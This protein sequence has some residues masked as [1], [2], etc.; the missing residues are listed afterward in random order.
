MW[1]TCHDKSLHCE[2]AFR[3]LCTLYTFL[4]VFSYETFIT[5]IKIYMYIYNILMI[6]IYII[7]FQNIYVYINF[8]L[9]FFLY[10]QLQQSP[11]SNSLTNQFPS[12]NHSLHYWH[13]EFYYFHFFS[14]HTHLR[15]FSSVFTILFLLT[16]LHHLQYKPL[17]I[18]W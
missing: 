6:Y 10:I 3:N 12:L 17:N 13:H 1:S 16:S 4:I 15:C 5:C 7:F 9:L 2:A 8:L 11:F 14:A 18:E